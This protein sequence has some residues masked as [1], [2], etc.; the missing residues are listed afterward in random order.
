MREEPIDPRIHRAREKARVHFWMV[1]APFLG[2]I[3]L[4]LAGSSLATYLTFRF[5]EG[6]DAKAAV[7]ISAGFLSLFSVLF[8]VV[9]VSTE[10]P[11]WIEQKRKVREIENELRWRDHQDRQRR[12]EQI[13]KEEGIDYD[14]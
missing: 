6:D 8:G 9:G 11:E 10:L 13:L 12:I 14:F 1:A 7:L 4:P 5:I 2:L 3:A